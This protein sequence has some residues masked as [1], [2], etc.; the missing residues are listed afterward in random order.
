MG[1]RKQMRGVTQDNKLL[2]V[3]QMYCQ[4]YYY[5][6]IMELRQYTY[7]SC[8]LLVFALGTFNGWAS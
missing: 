2:A 7:C 1:D 4:D 8:V 5:H 3:V 6:I